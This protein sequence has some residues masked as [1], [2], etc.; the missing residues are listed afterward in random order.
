MHIFWISGW[1]IPPGWLQALAADV[2]PDCTH[3]AVG[4][5]HDAVD[6][7]LAS[8]ADMLGGFSLGA[9]L[10]LAIADQRP[11]ILLAPFADLKAEAGL[12]GAVETVRIRKLQRML[13]RDIQSAV[14]D[15]HTRIGVEPPPAE[16]DHE[17]LAWGLE[18]M[19]EPGCTPPAL[20]AQSICI[21]GEQDPLLDVPVLTAVIPSIRIIPAPH[22]PQTLL[23]AAQQTLRLEFERE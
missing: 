10:L 19:L 3:E 21:A 6:R 8:D 16:H 12:G 22:H 7:A 11:R 17:A 5:A 14:T 13:R 4:P 15:F 20:P 9:H 1:S 18:R 23:E 2:M